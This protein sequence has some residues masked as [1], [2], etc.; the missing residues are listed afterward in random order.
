MEKEVR[1][2]GNFTQALWEDGLWRERRTDL[3]PDIGQAHRNG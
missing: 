3:A 2:G 1:A